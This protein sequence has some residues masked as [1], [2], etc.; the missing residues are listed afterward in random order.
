MSV[1][2]RHNSKEYP[3]L[4]TVVNEVYSQV[5]AMAVDDKKPPVPPIP[6]FFLCA[7]VLHLLKPCQSNVVITPT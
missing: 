2:R 1:V 5:T 4:I 7:A 6:R 3:V